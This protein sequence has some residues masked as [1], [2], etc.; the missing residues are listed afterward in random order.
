M[1][2]RFHRVA[3]AVAACALLT[4]GCGGQSNSSEDPVSSSTVAPTPTAPQNAR[5]ADD[6]CRST[7]PTGPIDHSLQNLS[8]TTGQATVAITGAEPQQGCYRFAR[9]G[10]A[11][12][13]VPIDSLLFLFKDEG[14][15]GVTIDMLVGDLTTRTALNARITVVVDGTAYGADTC[16]TTVTALSSTAVAGEF[17]CPT[18]TRV[19]GNPFAPLD[20]TEPEPSQSSP[21]PTV[22]VSGWFTVAPDAG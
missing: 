12:P 17:N 1:R 6:Q 22:A 8:F 20:D 14:S 18:A 11:D 7:P 5:V 19:F 10:N 3:M 21:L 4:A 13:A 2:S 9:W 15:D 16:A